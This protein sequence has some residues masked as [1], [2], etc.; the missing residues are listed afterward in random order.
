[1]LSGGA[2]GMRKAAA[3]AAGMTIV[4]CAAGTVDGTAIFGIGAGAGRCP[5][6]C[7]Y[8]ASILETNT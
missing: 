7:I 2:A 3:A 1:M 8:A 5:D 4:C 6:F